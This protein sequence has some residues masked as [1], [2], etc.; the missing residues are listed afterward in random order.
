LTFSTTYKPTLFESNGTTPTIK[1]RAVCFPM[2]VH[3]IIKGLYEL[4]SLQGFSGNKD[5]NQKVADAVD[6]LEHEPHDLKYGKWIYNAINDV[7]ASSNYDDP[8]IR[9]FLFAEIYKLGDS[10]FIE[11][12]ENAINEKLTNTQQQWIKS[13]MRDISDDLKAD[14][15]IATGLDEVL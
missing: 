12:I 1:A 4:V 3:E 11:F 14:D 8:R 5:Q 7:F 6:K 15:Y 2:L 10:E 13:T 9:E